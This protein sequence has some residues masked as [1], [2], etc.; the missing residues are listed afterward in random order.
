MSR[1]KK[2]EFIWS[3]LVHIGTRMWNDSPKDLTPSL[4][5]DEGLYRDITQRM[6]AIGMN[7]IVLDIGESLVYPSHPELAIEGSWSPDK[8]HDEVVRL[9]KLGLEP[10]PKLNFSATHDI[11]LGE[12][13]R[14]LSTPIYYR[15]CEDVIKDVAEIFGKETRFFHLGYDE[16]AVSEQTRRLYAAARQGALW[17]HDFE[18]FLGKAAATG[19]RPWIWADSFW[20]HPEEFAAKVPRSVLLSNWYYGRTFKEE[21]PFERRYEEVRLKA[22]KALDKLGYEDIPCATNWL[23]NYYDTPVN[24]VNWPMTVEYCLKNVSPEGLKGFMMAPWAFTEEKQRAFW[25]RGLD[26]VEASIKSGKRG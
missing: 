6:R 19:M 7:M 2:D 12:Y 11:W 25:M 18:W 3:A 1:K 4:R 10:I 8:L 17:W 22:Y 24:D 15:V 23:P 20:R 9:R 16:E 5:F 26:L 14:M 21:G 13:S